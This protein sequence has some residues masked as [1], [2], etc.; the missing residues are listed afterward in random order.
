M[1]NC[2]NCKEN[3]QIIAF[4]KLDSGNIRKICRTCK[5]KQVV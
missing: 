2:F 5:N 3:K 4:E 1:Q